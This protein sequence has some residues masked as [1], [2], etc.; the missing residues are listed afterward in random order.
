MWVG[1]LLQ[2]SKQLPL[3]TQATRNGAFIYEVMD[4][5]GRKTPEAMNPVFHLKERGERCHVQDQ[6]V[7]SG[8]DQNPRPF[9]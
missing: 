6:T 9:S 2:S 5:R 4:Y 8:W 3:E 1:S 7:G